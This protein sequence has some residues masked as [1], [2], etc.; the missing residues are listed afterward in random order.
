MLS[1]TGHI[2]VFR[3]PAFQLVICWQPEDFLPLFVTNAPTV[4]TLPVHARIDARTSALPDAVRS[5]AWWNEQHL[6]LQSYA[7]AFLVSPIDQ[8]RNILGKTVERLAPLSAFGNSVLVDAAKDRR[9][10]V[11]LEQVD[12]YLDSSHKPVECLASAL[13]EGPKVPSLSQRVRRFFYG[14]LQD[15]LFNTNVAF[16]ERAFN[17]VSFQTITPYE[18]VC[19]KL[20]K[21]EYGTAAE[22]AAEH[23]LDTDLVYEFQW[24]A[25]CQKLCP[26]EVLSKIHNTFYVIDQCLNFIPNKLDNIKRLLALGIKRITEPDATA[27]PSKVNDVV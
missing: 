21:E 23:G 2:A 27:Q 3:L 12:T 16:V 4:T 15:E 14:S 17:L 26:L 24:N 19:R 8:P 20:Q 11:V 18:D 6:V 5:I 13:V 22:L 25:T 10:I 9:C 1:L 7:G